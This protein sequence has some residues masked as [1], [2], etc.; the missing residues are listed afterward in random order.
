MF[1]LD[2]ATLCSHEM[3]KY[4]D[5]NKID[6]N[7]EIPDDIVLGSNNHI[8]YL[9]YS[10]LLDYGMRSKVYHNNLINTYKTN[11]QIFDPHYVIFHYLNNEEELFNIIKENIHPRYPKVALNKWITLSKFINNNY[12]GNGLLE[13]IK[14]ITSY[15]ELY[16][17][18]T[19]I[20]GYG[21]K[22][23]GL[24]LRLI[25]EMDILQLDS[26]I[27]DIPIDRHD[28]EISY[29]NSVVKSNNLNNNELKELGNIWIKA[30]SKEGISPVDI[31]KYLWTIGA[32]LCAK[33][34]CLECPL[35]SNCQKKL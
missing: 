7:V 33:K 22:T 6:A 31:D 27:D 29:L 32:N 1:N 30:A 16:N 23:G 14:K 10:C 21:Q 24:L 9:F 20:N 12:Q 19:A 35:K 34:K 5:K 3:K 8:L 28:V 4:F 13:H 2:K 26:E 25:Y 15:K 18:I 11:K 17:F